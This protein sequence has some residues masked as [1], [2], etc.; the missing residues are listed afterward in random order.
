MESALFCS[1]LPIWSLGGAGPRWVVGEGGVVG[2][3]GEEAGD[4]VGE[5]EGSS[6]LEEGVFD[7]LWLL[8]ADGAGG[9][10]GVDGRECG[11]GGVVESDHKGPYLGGE[12]FRP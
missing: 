6:A 10:V 2:C 4:V 7:G 1:W 11:D 3:E 9:V 8:V 12:G 5:L